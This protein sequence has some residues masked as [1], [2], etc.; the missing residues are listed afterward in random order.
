M[1]DESCELD[2]LIQLNQTNIMMLTNAVR[3]VVRVNDD[4][5][6]LHICYSISAVGVLTIYNTV[7]IIV[8]VVLANAD[9]LPEKKKND[10]I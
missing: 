6:W 7:R 2:R 8:Y 4:A 1:A 3:F 10:N 9:N 5:F